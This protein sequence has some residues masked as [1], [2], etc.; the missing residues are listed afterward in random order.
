MRVRSPPTPTLSA[1]PAPTTAAHCLTAP[2]SH[3]SIVPFRRSTA[4][5]PRNNS[6]PQYHCTA[7]QHRILVAPLHRLN[8]PS[9]MLTLRAL[10]LRGGRTSCPWADAA[11]IGV[12][13]WSPASPASHPATRLP[14]LLGRPATVRHAKWNHPPLRYKACCFFTSHGLIHFC[15]SSSLTVVSGRR[16]CR[17]RHI[18]S[19]CHL[20]VYSSHLLL[21][22]PPM[23]SF[24]PLGQPFSG[25][26]MAAPAHSQGDR[27]SKRRQPSNHDGR[28]TDRD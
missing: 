2:Q 15:A 22:A 17:T 16:S 14:F 5:L 23:K 20:V 28:V 27:H 9:P 25:S 4:L 21:P 6:T 26:C 1:F 19:P 18:I 11:G 3:G 12:C 13:R 8:T 10:A 7:R 24:F